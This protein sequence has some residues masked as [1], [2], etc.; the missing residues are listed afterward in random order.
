MRAH[1]LFLLFALSINAQNDDVTTPPSLADNSSVVPRFPAGL[2]SAPYPEAG[3]ATFVYTGVVDDGQGEVY[4][5]IDSASGPLYVQFTDDVPVKPTPNPVF[6]PP[7]LDVLCTK[8]ECPTELDAFAPQ[9]APLQPDNTLPVVSWLPPSCDP[10]TNAATQQC[11]TQLSACLAAKSLSLC[12]A[13]HSERLTLR[14]AVVADNDA[15]LQSQTDRKALRQLFLDSLRSDF[16]S[17][18]TM[19]T[20]A[21]RILADNANYPVADG[22]PKKKT[23]SNLLE[24]ISCWKG[25]LQNP[26][27]GAACACYNAHGRC[28][29][30]AGCSD[31]LPKE[32]FNHC[33]HYLSCTRAMCQGSGAA[34]AGAAPMVLLAMAAALVVLLG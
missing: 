14:A 19:L 34:T 30:A 17:A 7:Q 24:A 16:V 28:W 13:K 9:A 5:L 23:E 21:N 11:V 1:S 15:I 4:P 12:D 31:S 8:D 25:E 2:T 18:A 3:K 22:T 26:P 20:L 10:G 27:Y 32:D 6:S 29:R 33:F